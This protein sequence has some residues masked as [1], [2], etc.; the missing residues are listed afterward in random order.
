MSFEEYE[1]KKQAITKDVLSKTNEE[2]LKTLEGES[3]AWFLM[4][5]SGDCR[6]C[7]Y[8]GYSNCRLVDKN[9][10]LN[11]IGG[12]KAWLE[13]RTAENKDDTFMFE[14]SRH[15]VE[16]EIYNEEVERNNLEVDA[17]RIDRMSE[18]EYE[19][20]AKEH[21][22]IIK[23]LEENTSLRGLD[24]KGNWNKDGAK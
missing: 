9:E 20:F 14:A 16:T 5:Y 11:C 1:A 3:L 24:E 17:R 4:M 2:N 10:K 6:T 8:K 19:V 21:P 7:V 12:H 23:K 22:D 18:E 13:R 15:N